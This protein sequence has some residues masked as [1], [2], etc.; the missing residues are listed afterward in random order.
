MQPV[1]SSSKFTNCFGRIGHTVD[2]FSLDL[3]R[4]G[5]TSYGSRLCPNRL[6]TEGG[7]HIPIFLFERYSR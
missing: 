4:A 3:S 7:I 5:V 1:F 6:Y 2:S